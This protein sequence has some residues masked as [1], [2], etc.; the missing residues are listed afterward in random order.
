MSDAYIVLP[1]DRPPKAEES[2][3]VSDRLQALMEEIR[4]RLK[5]VDSE[6]RATSAGTLPTYAWLGGDT[7]PNRKM[8]VE[9]YERLPPGP[10]GTP[11]VRTI[12]VGQLVFEIKEALAGLEFP[13]GSELLVRSSEADLYESVKL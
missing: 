5:D 7:D 6:M 1:C 4:R 12:D 11:R 8:K 10:D 13:C 2:A 3:G 9:R